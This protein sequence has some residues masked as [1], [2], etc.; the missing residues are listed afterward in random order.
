MR[1]G[2]P[3]PKAKNT[4]ARLLPV[5]AAFEKCVLRKPTVNPGAVACRRPRLIRQ[6]EAPA[7][8]TGVG[9]RFFSPL[10]WGD[11]RRLNEYSNN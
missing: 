8:D 9:G 4:A 10:G 1:G 7:S 2:N 3:Y 11:Y 5:T 6:A